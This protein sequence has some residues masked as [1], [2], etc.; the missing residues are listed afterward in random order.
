MSN[1][2]TL[3]ALMLRLKTKQSGFTIV[4]LLIVIVVIGILAAITIVAYNGIQRRAYNSTQ[5]TSVSAYLKLLSLYRTDKGNYPSAVTCLGLNNV[6]TNGNGVKD[7]GDNGDRQVNQTTLNELAVYGTLPDVVITQ[8]AGTDGIKRGGVFF[9][10]V[11]PRIVWFVNG[12]TTD[13]GVPTTSSGSS[14]NNS[15]WCVY[16]LP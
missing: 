3:K 6:D 12:S 1:G 5:A 7:C 9:D 4:E 16:N 15:V 14:G 13:C 8:I 2:S 10:T 11:G